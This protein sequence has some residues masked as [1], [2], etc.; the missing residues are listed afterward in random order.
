MSWTSLSAGW[1]L[2]QS[3]MLE[4]WVC[5]SAGM[6]QPSW[7]ASRTACT[8]VVIH[9]CSDTGHATCSAG[10]SSRAHPEKMEPERRMTRWKW[11]WRIMGLCTRYSTHTAPAPWTLNREEKTKGSNTSNFYGLIA[12][13]GEIVRTAPTCPMTVMRPGSPPN[14]LMS[15]TTHCRAAIWSTSP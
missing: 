11:D 14:C 6:G 13:S 4:W 1:S 10:F 15:S 5:R 9:Q 12:M 7:R 3:S 8:T 2:R